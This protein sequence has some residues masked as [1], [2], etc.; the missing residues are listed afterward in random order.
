MSE[1]PVVV[2]A[3][4]PVVLPTPLPAG[5]INPAKV[6]VARLGAGSRRTMWAALE[7][8]VVLTGSRGMTA[9]DFPWWLLRYEHTAALR[10]LLA[11]HVDSGAVALATA[12]KHLSAL[13]GVLAEAWELGLMTAEDHLRATKI[14]NITGETLPAGRSVQENELRALFRVCMEDGRVAGARD[15]ALLGCLYSGGPRRAEI[16]A[17]VYDDDYDEATGRLRIRRAKGRKQRDVW[18]TAGAREA[19]GDWLAVRGTWKG[20][21]F[22][23]VN[24]GGKIGTRAMS[25]QAVANIVDRRVRAAGINDFTP[26]DMRRTFVGDLL[27]AGADLLTVQR[28]AGHAHPDTTARYDRRD[29]KTKRAAGELLHVP[30]RRQRRDE[31]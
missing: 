22:V 17:L 7:N 11:D 18:L 29:D 31:S 20:P 23:A 14:K 30:Y 15:A 21:L 8:L 16:V 1:T 12:N 3:A 19:M 4:V 27:D 2:T 10:S 24:K 9:E 26:H 6:Y 5:V 13:R 25:G 28:L